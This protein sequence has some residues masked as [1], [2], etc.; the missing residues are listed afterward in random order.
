MKL[1]ESE[2]RVME[3]TACVVVCMLM[4]RMISKAH[5]S[6]YVKIL[7]GLVNIKVDS[8]FHPTLS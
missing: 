4:R 8:Y 6:V 7:T 1:V 5:V 2:T 3:D